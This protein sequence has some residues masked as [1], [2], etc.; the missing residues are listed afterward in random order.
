MTTVRVYVAGE[1][2]GPKFTRGTVRQ[3]E[4]VLASTRAA[5]RDVATAI[6]KR[7]RE[8]IR[9]AGRFGSRWTEGLTAPVTEGGG[10]IRVGVA[11]T[12]LKVGFRVH[13][14]GATIKAKN[15]S[16][17]LWIPFPG[18]G[19]QGIMARD[20]PGKLFRITSKRGNQVLMDAATKTPKFFGRASVRIPKRFKVVE[21]ATEEARKIQ[22]YYDKRLAVQKGLI[23]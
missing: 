5:A 23:A 14:F 13:Q 2:A 17:L 7:G 1:R 12:L 9:S 20:Y 10:S 22:T 21:I 6:E 4:A 8:N 19:T 11:H 15:P 3:R 16:G 18:A